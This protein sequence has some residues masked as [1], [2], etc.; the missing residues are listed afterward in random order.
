MRGFANEPLCQSQQHLCTTWFCGVINI[1][2]YNLLELLKGKLNLPSSVTQH[3][4]L[5]Q[6]CP[7]SISIPA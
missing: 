7:L 2:T 6:S 1:K 5:H 4:V 3:S